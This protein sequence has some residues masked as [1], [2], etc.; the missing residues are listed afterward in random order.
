MYQRILVPLDGTTH[1]ERALPVAARIA[2]ASGASM[3]LLQVADAPVEYG[4]LSKYPSPITKENL[5]VE[6]TGDSGYLATV[7]ESDELQGIE[8]TTEVLAGAILPTLISAVQA[9]GI[10]LIVMCSHGDTGLKRWMLGSVAQ[11]LARHSPAPV[12]VLREG[13]DLSTV[14][15]DSLRAL[16]ALDGSPFAEA[17]LVPAAQS[18]AALAA[19]GRG[20]L[21]LM[22]VVTGPASYRRL[23]SELHSDPHRVGRELRDARAYLSS[24]ATRLRKGELADLG[25]MVTWSIAVEADV[26]STLI[27]VAEYG[28]NTEDFDGCDLIAIATHGRSGVQRLVMGSIAQRILGATKLPLLIVR[29]QETVTGHEPEPLS[30]VTLL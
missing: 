14:R 13:L 20:A 27:K 18:M 9:K 23:R 16:V 12:L 6:R 15:H 26:A 8:I 5:A 30:V 11:E 19:P 4:A 17:A 25:L 3:V 7:A 21:H 1:A 29:P 10:D 28:R 24:V 2:R 22:Q